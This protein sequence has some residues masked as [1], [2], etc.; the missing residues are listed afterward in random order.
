M[1]IF[2]DSRAGVSN[3]NCSVGH[4]KAF[5]VT[6]GPHYNADAITADLNLLETAIASLFPE[7]D[8]MN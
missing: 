6:R 2:T 7:K 8:I 4:M 5:K 3:S 1:I